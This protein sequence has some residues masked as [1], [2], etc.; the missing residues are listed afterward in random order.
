LAWGCGLYSTGSR[1]GP[2]AGCCECGDEP[3]GSCA[4]ELVRYKTVIRPIVTWVCETWILTRK[5]ELTILI[6]ER[7]VFR[8]VFGA[9]C[10]RVCYRMR[11]NEEV[12]R[13]YQELDLVTVIRT[14]RLKWLSHANRM[15]DHREPKTALQVQGRQPS[16]TPCNH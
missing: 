1:Q 7:K 12:Y 9:I 2:V 5:G 14:S 11:T 16:A 13:I 3:S 10:E 6:R 15:E 8:R 4:T